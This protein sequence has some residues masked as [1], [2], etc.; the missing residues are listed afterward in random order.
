[1][2]HKLSDS[3]PGEI[4][5]HPSY[6][7]STTSSPGW[8]ILG[9]DIVLI[10]ESPD[11]PMIT[12]AGSSSFCSWSSIVI[13]LDGNTFWLNQSNV[14]LVVLVAPFVL[15]YTVYLKWYISV[16]IFDLHFENVY[17]FSNGINHYF[18]LFWLVFSLERSLNLL[19]C[20]SFQLRCPIKFYI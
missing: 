14:D 9:F 6:V 12:W 20:M 10:P 15:L 11:A 5:V 8:P 3:R 17:I 2:L 4:M 16:D 13:H 18:Y 7:C 1:M 19:M